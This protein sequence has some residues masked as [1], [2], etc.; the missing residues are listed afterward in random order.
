MS[1]HYLGDGD[2]P[3]IMA[4]RELLPEPVNSPCK[5]AY[6][7]IPEPP[8]KICSFDEAI[9]SPTAKMYSFRKT[10]IFLCRSKHSTSFYAWVCDQDGKIYF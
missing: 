7:F 5:K 4:A 9:Y 10:L 8:R 1:I 6:G 3:D 2:N